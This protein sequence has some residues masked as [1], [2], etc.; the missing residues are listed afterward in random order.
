MSIG[1]RIIFLSNLIFLCFVFMVATHLCKSVGKRMGV[2]ADRRKSG[3]FSIYFS[4]DFT[5]NL[6]Y[7]TF[8][9]SLFDGIRSPWE[10]AALMALHISIEWVENILLAS[11]VGFNLYSWL[12]ARLCPSLQA[13]L[14]WWLPPGC[15]RTSGCQTFVLASTATCHCPELTR[16]R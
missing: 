10:F 8:Y 4:L 16:L 1:K 6:F 15:I 3:T 11:V 9:R 5:C 13:A 14:V 7:Y 12:Y 2:V